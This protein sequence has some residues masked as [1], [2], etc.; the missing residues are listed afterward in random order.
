MNHSWSC[1][2]AGGAAKDVDEA[3]VGAIATAL[4]VAD[5]VL[6]PALLLTIASAETSMPI[7]FAMFD[8]ACATITCWV[9]CYY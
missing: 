3:G 4:V 8:I 2:V 7:V 1:V 6:L 9:H 5:V